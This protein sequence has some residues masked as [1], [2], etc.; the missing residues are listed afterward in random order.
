MDIQLGHDNAVSDYRSVRQGFPLGVRLC[1]YGMTPHSR[2]ARDTFQAGEETSL[3][4]SKSSG[5]FK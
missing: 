2:N 4:N 1:A 5:R 3:R